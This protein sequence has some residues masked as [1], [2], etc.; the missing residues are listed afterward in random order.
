M[1][2][3]VELF[4]GAFWRDPYPAYA[5]LRADEPVSQAGARGTARSGCSL[6]YADVRAALADPRLSKDWRFTLPPERGRT[7]PRRASR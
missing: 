1:T 4:E 6:G 3:T 5:A 2:S 7:A